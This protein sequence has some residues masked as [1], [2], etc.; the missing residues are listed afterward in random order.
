[1]EALTSAVAGFIGVFNA[2]GEYFMSLMTGIIPTLLILLAVINFI[3]RLI[4]EERVTHFMK[5]CTKNMILRY[6]ILPMLAIIVLGDPMAHTFG[7]FLNE[8]Y[9]PSY[10]DACMTFLHPATGIFPHVCPGELF[11]F[12]GIADGITSLGYDSNELAIWYLITGV[13]IM[14]IRAIMTE[15]VFAILQ[16]RHQVKKEAE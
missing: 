6:T 12:M 14:F 2:G 3:I 1:M 15:R 4:G 10:Y 11:I 16:K 9:K 5:K 13:I 7:R 8:K